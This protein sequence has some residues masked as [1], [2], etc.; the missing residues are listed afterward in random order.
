MPISHDEAAKWSKKETL[1]GII[2]GATIAWFI[3]DYF[4]KEN[5]ES[6]IRQISDLKEEKNKLDAEKSTSETNLATCKTEKIS[7]ENSIKQNYVSREE[8]NRCTQSNSQLADENQK[9]KDENIRFSAQVQNKSA[10]L[11]RQQYLQN[12]LDNIREELR[13][14]ISSRSF[15]ISKLTEQQ[16]LAR[17]EQQQQLVDQLNK[18]NCQ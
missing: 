2:I 4:H 11:K 9:I 15:S 5:K 10:C 14:G 16:I 12:Q 8:F 17:Q 6:Y 7:L 1:T 18:L 3:I 13:S